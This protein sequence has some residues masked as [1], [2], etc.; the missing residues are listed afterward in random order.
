MHLPLSGP[1]CRG[2]E[3]DESG[4]CCKCDEENVKCFMGV[5]FLDAQVN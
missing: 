5:L 4:R 1:G 3:G 2:D